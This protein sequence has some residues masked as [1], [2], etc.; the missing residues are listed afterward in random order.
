MGN[1]VYANV[2]LMG[3]AWQKGLIPVGLDAMIR[4]IDLNGVAPAA[5]KRAFHIGRL[6]AADPGFA[7]SYL[8]KKVVVPSTLDETI[9]TRS[10]FLTQYQNKKYAHT[11]E[12]ALTPIRA[13]ETELGLGENLSQAAAKALF[14]VMSYKDEY[15]VARLH[16][17][18]TFKARIAQEFEGDY[19]VKYHLAPPIMNTQLDGRGRPKKKEFGASMGKIFAV[20]A[21]LKF[22]RGSAFDI[23][24]Y[25]AERKSERALIVWVEDMLE[26]ITAYLNTQNHGEAVNIVENILK[27]RGYGPVKDENLARIKPQIERQLARYIEASNNL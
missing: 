24:G 8:G 27:I 14:K 4:A 3:L 18:K 7:E 5:N 13:R 21:R 2:M 15:E 16:R 23:F 17:D 11:Y 6:A 25:S 9:A 19:A 12:T 22:L 10:A 20:L 26:N 1:S